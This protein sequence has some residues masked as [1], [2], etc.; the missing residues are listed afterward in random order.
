MCPDGKPGVFSLKFFDE[1]KRFIAGFYSKIAI[2]QISENY[3]QIKVLSEIDMPGHG[4]ICDTAFAWGRVYAVSFISDTISV[5]SLSGNKKY[6][7]D[8]GKKKK[9]KKK[10]KSK[11]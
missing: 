10:K 1:D 5:V 2:M 6:V 11:D 4:E 8:V 3:K 9:K 7:K